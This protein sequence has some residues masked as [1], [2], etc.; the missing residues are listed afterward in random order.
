[1]PLT[2]VK[3]SHQAK[4][5]LTALSHLC[6]LVSLERF[7]ASML[8]IDIAVIRHVIFTVMGLWCI[9]PQAVAVRTSLN[10]RSDS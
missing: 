1:M 3:F 10:S 2:A 7:K 9:S 5:G 8:S 6:A 4:H